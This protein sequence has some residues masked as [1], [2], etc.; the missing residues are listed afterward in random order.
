MT[1]ILHIDAS[2]RTAV[3]GSRLLT[4]EFVEAFAQ[5]SPDTSIVYRNLVAQPPALIDEPWI[6]AAFTPPEMLLP[7]M[8][9]VLAMSDALIDELFAAEVI[10][11]GVPMHNFGICTLLKCYID[12][13]VRAGCTFQFTAHG[14][15]GLVTGKRVVVMMTRGS[16]YSSSPMADLDFQQ[17]YLKTVF[18]FIG[19]E[20]ITVIVCDGMDTGNRDQALHGARQAIHAIVGQFVAPEEL[21]LDLVAVA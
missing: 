12:Q 15:R 1:T 7:E 21:Q 2:P 18:G 6:A 4:R 19:I 14:P 16:D 5:A 9:S 13:I 11:I 10:V 8:Q 20:D 3:S 17:P